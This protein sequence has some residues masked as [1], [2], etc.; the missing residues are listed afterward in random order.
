MRVALVLVVVLV[1]GVKQNQLQPEVGLEFEKNKLG[2]TC[3][4]LIAA[5]TLATQLML[6]LHTILNYASLS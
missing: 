6:R 5:Y 1:T 2:L 4:K 3:D